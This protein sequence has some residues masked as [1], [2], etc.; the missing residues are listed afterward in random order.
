MKLKKKWIIT[1]PLLI[2]I[3][4]F[5]GLY[6]YYYSE[7][8]NALTTTDKKWIGE[9]KNKIIDFYLPDDYPIY[10]QSGVF[11]AFINSFS[12]DTGLEFNIV[13]YDKG[14][15]ITNKEYKFKI[16][17]NKEKLGKNDLLLQEDVY[18]VYGKT[19]ELVDSLNQLDGK[20]V[21]VLTE[22]SDEMV[23]YLKSYPNI[24]LKIYEKIDQMLSDYENSK[25]DFIITCHN[26][27]LD[28]T[29]NNEKYNI[30]HV[31]TEV[32]SKIVFSLNENKDMSKMNEI[33]TK[34]YN[35]WKKND[36]LKVYNDSILEFYF[37]NY[38]DINDK[39]KT[40]F[41]TKTYSYGYVEN[42]PYETVK[43]DVLYGIAG[44]YIN[45]FLRLSNSLSINYKEYKNVDE[46]KQAIEKKEV[47]IYFNYF[48]FEHQD[49]KSTNSIFIEKYV[50]LG[51]TKD[52]YVI[53]SFESMKGLKVSIL[54]NNA[55][56]N[57]FKDNS[58][59]IL[60]P[61]GNLNDLLKKSDNNLIVLDKEV[62]S[63]YKNSKL[64]NYDL[65]FESTITNDYNFM[66]SNSDDNKIF[67]D[68]F[69]Y[70]ISTN[71]YFNYRNRGLNSLNI[72]IWESSSFENL[73]LILL[74]IT[75][76]PLFTAM[77][78]YIIYKNRKKTK[79]IRKDEK[80]KYIDMLTSLKNRNYLNYNI[81]LWN[82]SKKFPQSII[83]VDLNNVK[84]V[85]DNYG[86]SEGDKLI[87]EAA[88]MLI[89][90]QLENTEIIRTDG[91]EFLIYLVG[92]SE[93]QISKYAKNL[94]KEFK[95]LPYQFG[96]AIGYSMIQDEIKSI[97]DAINEAV[98]NMKKN[99][100][101]NR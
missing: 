62:Y 80:R 15:K 71:S 84:Y 98:L 47:D 18:V 22:D 9:Q 13:P 43:K 5:L 4:L 11:R 67:Y 83:I 88:S 90:A 50:V 101:E 53:N 79:L 59:A 23:Y 57:F 35:N 92:Y 34:Y 38:D 29:I 45:R 26:M 64:K 58:K 14:E 74:V 1:I 93:E 94:F 25:I 6:Y 87:V 54:N 33:F 70:I 24:K 17:D 69:N 37:K 91:N 55:I 40:E 97:D 3:L 27:Y 51:N 63:F 49:Y 65:L 100:E 89:N 12:E 73:Y 44:E 21:G 56:Y 86:H 10:G 2:V 31:F 8:G 99:K 52:N 77:I 68:V 32:T 41:L 7:D 72:S 78:A 30:K 16:L 85:N 76:G 82:E 36:Y 20:T 60:V 75:L 66:I 39:T 48:N 46:L 19:K 95:A 81:K 28:K 96:A 42:K 61:V